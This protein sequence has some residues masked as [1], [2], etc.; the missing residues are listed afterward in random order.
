M[1]YTIGEVSSIFNISNDMIRY[2][3]KKGAV[4]SGRNKDNNY[5]FYSTMNVFW[6]F[7]AMQHKSWGLPIHKINDVRLHSFT[8]ETDLFLETQIDTLKKSLQYNTTLQRRL[9]E[10][11]ERSF[12]ASHN[13]GN[14]WIAQIPACFRSHLVKSHGDEYERIDITQESSRFL[15]SDEL[16]PFVD[17][18]LTVTGKEV[19]WEISIC[20]D[21][22]RDINVK[23]LEEFS[24]IPEQICLCT[25][26]DI[27]EIGHFNPDVFNVLLAYAQE[28][29]VDIPDHA[30]IR[31]HILGRGYEKGSFRRILKLYIPIS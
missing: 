12:L 9:S 4:R 19:D 20:A 31:G 13:I 5:R 29:N 14:F 10:L 7:E 23:P 28:K 26:V 15:F 8:Q 11:K 25:H 27:G 24:Y 21:Y 16:L 17:S 18:G 2:Y 1:K 30:K 3:E 22:L 6:L